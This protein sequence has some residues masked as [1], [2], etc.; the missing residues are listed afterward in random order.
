MSDINEFYLEML[1]GVST[2]DLSGGFSVKE[3]Q[4]PK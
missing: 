3:N 1:A 4:S 2:P